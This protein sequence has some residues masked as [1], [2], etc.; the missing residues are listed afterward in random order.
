VIYERAL[1]AFPLTHFLWLTYTR[2]LEAHLKIPDII[3][4][5]FARAVRNTPWVGVMW[6]RALNALERS[7]APDE[8]QAAVYQRAIAAGLQV[9]EGFNV[10]LAQ[11]ELQTWARACQ[12]KDKEPDKYV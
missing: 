6:A 4:A 12:E 11:W 9:R 5:V 3:N 7:G 8:E 2:Y 1:A 10:P